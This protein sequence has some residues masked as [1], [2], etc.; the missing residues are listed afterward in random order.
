MSCIAFLCTFVAIATLP[1]G[2]AQ[3]SRFL[4]DFG[5]FQIEDSPT[6]GVKSM[7]TTE[8]KTAQGNAHKVIKRQVYSAQDYGL[9]LPRLKPTPSPVQEK[10]FKEQIRSL[11]ISSRDGLKHLY[12]RIG[13]TQEFQDTLMRELFRSQNAVAKPVDVTRQSVD[14]PNRAV[15]E[16]T[17]PISNHRGGGLSLV[18]NNFPG[19]GQQ[20]SPRSYVTSG[21]HPG[22]GSR[23]RYNVHSGTTFDTSPE[24]NTRT[25]NINDNIA[26]NRNRGSNPAQ[27]RSGAG[28]NTYN[29]NILGSSLQPGQSRLQETSKTWTYQQERREQQLQ[30]TESHNFQTQRQPFTTN[31]YHPNQQINNNQYHQH[32]LINTN[33]YNS[34]HQSNKNNQNQHQQTAPPT[35]VN[36]SNRQSPQKFPL[37]QLNHNN[38]KMATNYLNQSE[39]VAFSQQQHYANN[40]QVHYTDHN[41]HYTVQNVQSQY[42]QIPLN[43]QGQRQPYG[44]TQGNEHNNNELRSFDSQAKSTGYNQDHNFKIGNSAPPQGY[45]SINNGND[46]TRKSYLPHP[47]NMI[48]TQNERIYPQQ[49]GIQSARQNADGYMQP[50]MQ[51]VNNAGSLL[52]LSSHLNSSSAV[53][54]VISSSDSPQAN[55]TPSLPVHTIPTSHQASAAPP[56]LQL[57]VP[58]HPTT[59]TISSTTVTTTT[60]SQPPP[61]QVVDFLNTKVII[62]PHINNNPAMRAAFLKV[63]AKAVS[64][65]QEAMKHL[66]TRTKP[67]VGS[68]SP[69]T[70]K[71][72]LVTTSPTTVKAT[73]TTTSAPIYNL[74]VEMAP[75]LYLTWSLPQNQIDILKG[76]SLTTILQSIN[77]S[78]SEQLPGNGFIEQFKTFLIDTLLGDPLSYIPSDDSLQNQKYY[79]RL[80]L[81]PTILVKDILGGFVK[82]DSSPR[83]SRIKRSHLSNLKKYITQRDRDLSKSTNKCSG[84][85]ACQFT[86]IKNIKTIPNNLIFTRTKPALKKFNPTQKN[87]SNKNEPIL[88]QNS[89]LNLLKA[90]LQSNRNFQ[91]TDNQKPYKERKVVNTE[92]QVVHLND[93]TICN[94]FKDVSQRSKCLINMRA[95]HIR[96]SHLQCRKVTMEEKKTQCKRNVV[97]N[98]SQQ[99]SVVRNI[100][101]Q[102]SVVVQSEKIT[103]NPSR[104]WTEKYYKHKHVL[105]RRAAASSKSLPVLRFTWLLPKDSFPAAPLETMRYIMDKYKKKEALHA[106][107]T[108]NFPE[109]THSVLNASSSSS[110]HGSS[111]GEHMAY[112]NKLI[113]AANALSK[114]QGRSMDLLA[115]AVNLSMF[116]S[117]QE[118]VVMKSDAYEN[119]SNESHHMNLPLINTKL[120]PVLTKLASVSQVAIPTNHTHK[121]AT[122]T[123]TNNHFISRNM[124]DNIGILKTTNVPPTPPHLQPTQGVTKSSHA[125]IDNF[126]LA[127]SSKFPD[128]PLNVLRPLV[129]HLMQQFNSNNSAGSSHLQTIPA[130]S[131]QPPSVNV[132]SLTVQLSSF[133][134][135]KTISHHRKVSNTIVE[136]QVTQPPIPE[137]NIPPPI[138]SQFPAQT[139]APKTLSQQTYAQRLSQ[140]TT[141]TFQAATPPFTSTSVFT[142]RYL[143]M[144]VHFKG[145]PPLDVT[146]LPSINSSITSPS[147]FPTSASPAE[148]AEFTMYLMSTLKSSGQNKSFSFV[149]HN[150]SANDALTSGKENLTDRQNTNVANTASSLTNPLHDISSV[151]KLNTEPNSKILSQTD[152]RQSNVPNMSLESMLFKS[153]HLDNVKPRSPHIDLGHNKSTQGH[154]MEISSHSPQT[155]IKVNPQMVDYV[156]AALNQMLMSNSAF[157]VLNADNHVSLPKGTDLLSQP[158]TQHTHSES[159]PAVQQVN[160]A[161]QLSGPRSSSQLSGPHSPSQLSGP[162]NPSQL[163]TNLGTI[164]SQPNG[165]LIDT[166]PQGKTEISQQSVRTHVDLS[167]QNI[168]SEAGLLATSMCLQGQQMSCQPTRPSPR[169]VSFCQQRCDT[170]TGLCSSALCQCSCLDPSLQTA[171]SSSIDKSS[172]PVTSNIGHADK[173]EINT[174]QSGSFQISMVNPELKTSVATTTDSTMSEERLRKFL[175]LMEKVKGKKSSEPAKEEE[176]PDR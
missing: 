50:V 126:M 90:N 111:V 26:R 49:N 51:P 23:T 57:T 173:T 100:S 168:L 93:Q 24:S 129:S 136:E 162:Q 142:N 174:L 28:S 84:N 145:L 94:H 116:Q 151:N 163:S 158:S 176:P 53:L 123:S 115:S 47:T 106:N 72:D 152:A 66:Q 86:S 110:Q 134:T 117:L 33:R 144:N 58:T 48:E 6:N 120:N 87:S 165:H 96:R 45:P 167:H 25:N 105:V 12:D 155:N 11:P 78:R 133:P 81:G 18:S 41:Q 137:S 175:T 138:L 127:M 43:H 80:D 46:L 83:N 20:S 27:L 9:R 56:T 69:V 164:S 42:Q 82:F 40:D 32:Q 113:E 44:I 146:T 156:G 16:N 17:G 139:S 55:K 95:H 79:D 64:A 22:T 71:Q 14:T 19:S 31:Q 159:Q 68:T 128:V 140:I 141:P 63:I 38:D 119:H 166:T 4:A 76:A 169:L 122:S 124:A 3:E 1:N 34:N 2:Q 92:P 149:S 91:I 107:K 161:S 132:T 130:S 5:S 97:R 170:S 160:L 171:V 62:P 35:Q 36:F 104:L 74:H 109:A 125:D 10:F 37:N 60:T 112:L 85:R 61:P 148:V 21:A 52:P 153:Q 30:P 157:N 98:I 131:F 73:S 102:S 67:L 65:N 150:D 172:V 39:Q 59:R 118:G 147:V 143:T 54:K 7:V 8:W 108:A 70:I 29:S 135:D 101:Q 75:A 154:A 13:F 15:T 121:T 114:L 77:T 88:K 89:F 103:L 99:S